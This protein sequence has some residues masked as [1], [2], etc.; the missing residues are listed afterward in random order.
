MIFPV[1]F[2][3]ASNGMY[4]VFVEIFSGLIVFFLKSQIFDMA[5]FSHLFGFVTG[6]PNISKK[7]LWVR[8]SYLAISCW[9][10]WRRVSASSKMAAMRFWV[11][12]FGRG[13][14]RDFKILA[15]IFGCAPPTPFL[16]IS[17]L[18]RKKDNINIAAG[19]Y[20]KVKKLH[21]LDW[22]QLQYLK[23]K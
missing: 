17:D 1:S 10:S 22:L 20:Q 14:F 7:R 2:S 3:I 19:I 4:F 5:T 23:L 9:F 21:M 11:S 6:S 12:R 8:A 15:E 16:I 13:I 18:F